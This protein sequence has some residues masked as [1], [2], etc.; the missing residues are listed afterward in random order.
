MIV[1]DTSKATYTVKET[2][3]GRGL[4]TA[5]GSTGTVSGAL[6]IDKTTPSA[7]TV[8][9]ITVDISK[10]TS[11]SS[12]RD[13]R[14]RQQWLESTKYP[15]A[16]FVT[17]RLEGLPDTAYTDGQ[18]LTF[19]IIGDMTIRTVTKELTFDTK[20]KAVG[21]LF[22]GTATTQFNMTDFGFDPP[23]IAGLLTAENGVVLELVIAAQ[24][25]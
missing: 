19:Q 16:T 12:Q 8:E 11:D 1:A 14:I 21:D 2:F 17:K 24:R 7:S 5:I 25:G 23:S 6:A 22:T 3:V 20:G 13:N 15:T 9:T 18:E 4:A 10:L